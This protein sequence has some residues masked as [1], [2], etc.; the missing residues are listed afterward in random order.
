MSPAASGD[1][2]PSREIRRA[3]MMLEDWFG[4][5][6]EEID[7][8]E[9]V[10]GESFTTVGSEGTVRNRTDSL[11]ALREDREAYVQSSPTVLVE[12]DEIT[13]HLELHGTHMLTFEKRIRVDGEW[14][15]RRCSLWLR[16]TDQSPTGLQ[17]LHLHETPIQES[18]AVDEE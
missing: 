11:E 7:A 2:D 9:A 10:L 12:V 6:R 18:E 8:I 16:E 3:H 5:I 4:G 15:A 14:E 1:V 13:H 17:W